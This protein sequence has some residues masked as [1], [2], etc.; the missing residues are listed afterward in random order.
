MEQSFLG[1]D[2]SSSGQEAFDL[3]LNPK[4]DS[5]VH[6]GPKLNSYLQL[7]EFSSQPPVLFP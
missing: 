1:A 2:S 7:D 4:V 5:S 6:R 3:S